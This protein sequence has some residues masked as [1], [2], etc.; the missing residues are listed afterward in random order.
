[1][2]QAQASLTEEHQFFG[3]L[4]CFMESA[5]EDDDSRA[6]QV[7]QQVKKICER[8]RFLRLQDYYRAHPQA[9]TQQLEEVYQS[10]LPGISRGSG[11]SVHQHS[12]A[13]R[14]GLPAMCLTA[15]D[16]NMSKKKKAELAKQQEATI[17]NLLRN[18]NVNP[19]P[20]SS[21]SRSRRGAARP[22][23]T[24]MAAGEIEI[25]GETYTEREFVLAAVELLTCPEINEVKGGHVLCEAHPDCV[26]QYAKPYC[27]YRIVADHVHKTALLHQHQHSPGQEHHHHQR[28]KD[29]LFMLPPLQLPSGIV[30]NDNFAQQVE[31]NKALRRARGGTTTAPQ[32]AG[33]DLRREHVKPF[34]QLETTL[35]LR[36]LAWLVRGGPVLTN[37]MPNHND[38][39][40]FPN[41]AFRIGRDIE[42]SVDLTG[43]N[44]IHKRNP[45]TTSCQLNIQEMLD[46]IENVKQKIQC[47]FLMKK[48]T[49]RHGATSLHVQDLSRAF[50]DTS[51]GQGLHNAR[52]G[53]NAAY[54][55]SSHN[56][57]DD[58]LFASAHHDSSSH[59]ST[60]SRHAAMIDS[61]TNKYCSK[62]ASTS[63]ESLQRVCTKEHSERLRAYKIQM[64]DFA[65]NC[66]SYGP[67]EPLHANSLLHQ[68]ISLDDTNQAQ[69]DASAGLPLGLGMGASKVELV[70]LDLL[71]YTIREHEA[72]NTRVED[73][74]YFLG[75][76]KKGAEV[77]KVDFYVRLRNVM[78]T[79]IDV[80]NFARLVRTKCNIKNDP[81]CDRDPFCSRPLDFSPLFRTI[82][83]P[84]HWIPMGCQYDDNPNYGGGGP[85]GS[86]LTGGNG[87]INPHSHSYNTGIEGGRRSNINF[88]SG[89]AGGAGVPDHPPGGGMG[90]S[91]PNSYNLNSGLQGAGAQQQ[92]QDQQYNMMN[93]R[94]ASNLQQAALVRKQDVLA[95]LWLLVGHGEENENKQH[96]TPEAWKA[97]VAGMTKEEMEKQKPPEMVSVMWS[98]SHGGE[99]TPIHKDWVK[100]TGSPLQTSKSLEFRPGSR[101]CVEIRVARKDLYAGK[102]L[103]HIMQSLHELHVDFGF[104]ERD[105]ISNLPS[106]KAQAA[107]IFS[108]AHA[109]V[110]PFMARLAN[111]EADVARLRR[112]MM[113]ENFDDAEEDQN[114]KNSLL[115]DLDGDG[116]ISDLDALL[117]MVKEESSMLSQRQAEELDEAIE[118]LDTGGEQINPLSRS[119]MAALAAFGDAE[120]DDDIVQEEDD[121]TREHHLRHSL[122]SV[123]SGRR[124]SKEEQKKKRSAIQT[125]R[126]RQKQK[127]V[128]KA[129]PWNWIRDK[130]KTFGI[131]IQNSVNQTM[132]NVWRNLP[133]M[134]RRKLLKWKQEQ[135]GLQTWKMRIAKALYAHS[136]TV[137]K[138]YVT[139]PLVETHK[140]SQTLQDL[141]ELETGR[142]RSAEHME[143]WIERK[144]AQR[145]LGSSSGLGSS[146]GHFIDAGKIKKTIKQRIEDIQNDVPVVI[147]RP[148]KEGEGDGVEE[149][150]SNTP[151]QD[152]G[153][154][155]AVDQQEDSSTSK[156][157]ANKNNSTATPPALIALAPRDLFER[158]LIAQLVEQNR[159]RAREEAVQFEEAIGGRTAKTQSARENAPFDSRTSIEKEH[160]LKE[161]VEQIRTE[162][163]LHQKRYLD[164]PLVNMLIDPQTGA[165]A[166]D[167]KSR[168]NR[169]LDFFNNSPFICYDRSRPLVTPV[170]L[171]KRRRYDERMRMERRQ[172]RVEAVQQMK[173]RSQA[174]KEGTYGKVKS[175]VA[176]TLGYDTTEQDEIRKLAAEEQNIELEAE[177]K[178]QIDKELALE[179]SHGGGSSARGTT[180]PGVHAGTTPSAD[181][182]QPSFFGRWFSG[183]SWFGG[184]GDGETQ[185]S[186]PALGSVA[187]DLVDDWAR[188]KEDLFKDELLVD[189]INSKS[190]LEMTILENT[191]VP[192]EEQPSPGEPLTALDC[193]FAHLLM[194][195]VLEG[196]DPRKL[197]EP[198]YEVPFLSKGI[199]GAINTLLESGSTPS[200]FATS[201]SGGPLGKNAVPEPD[202]VP[203]PPHPLA[204]HLILS[205]PK[206]PSHV[207]TSDGNEILTYIDFRSGDPVAWADPKLMWARGETK[208]R[209]GCVVWI[210]LSKIRRRYKKSGTR[211]KWFKRHSQIGF[212]EHDIVRLIA[213]QGRQMSTFKDA[214]GLTTWSSN[215]GTDRQGDLYAPGRG[216]FGAPPPGGHGTFNNPLYHSEGAGGPYGF[217]PFVPNPAN[218]FAA[219]AE[220][221]QHP[222]DQSYSHA[223]SPSSPAGAARGPGGG[224]GYEDEGAASAYDHSGAASYSD[225]FN[226]NN[227]EA[228][229]RQL[230]HVIAYQALPMY[231]EKLLQKNRYY[232]M[233]RNHEFNENSP[234]FVPQNPSRPSPGE[235][236]WAESMFYEKEREQECRNLVS[237]VEE[238]STEP[239][240]SDGLKHIPEKIVDRVVAE[241]QSR[242]AATSSLRGAKGEGTENSKSGT[243][244]GKSNKETGGT[245][246]QSRSSGTTSKTARTPKKIRRRKLIVPVVKPGTFISDI[247]SLFNPHQSEF[248]NREDELLDM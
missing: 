8:E 14:L 26:R 13:A 185:S 151:G 239:D 74:P 57:H 11:S 30:G 9:T 226:D 143:Q 109:D 187:G 89:A 167:P 191:D 77:E 159:I 214:G 135:F 34:T 87:I 19:H 27:N 246:D 213:V 207:V 225:A 53:P 127:R 58:E 46:Y 158:K 100:G 170:Q 240:T 237:T 248:A 174:F 39:R 37:E 189:L 198:N 22:T 155:H 21:N 131:T 184:G 203:E 117:H 157:Q 78:Q 223:G 24:P 227:G 233:R 119:K 15:T 194:Q 180:A 245:S 104:G 33:F 32:D 152:A 61:E 224:Y 75:V 51:S 162:Q 64:D 123:F 160:D 129:D 91:T 139:V 142:Y 50:S 71:R 220:G 110:D 186:S 72:E 99:L 47:C 231:Q 221:A 116:K 173:E 179:N 234:F 122:R 48:A 35:Y 62:L 4:P 84:E 211:M 148:A 202:H 201:S 216:P 105:E 238:I 247:Q 144:A 69:C 52:T 43:G 41:P 113:A 16:G 166:I 219:A 183:S 235:K 17:A 132:T 244:G 195:Q 153:A 121:E 136:V 95:T 42:M 206:K 92:I 12:T 232:V 161:A 98:S 31:E 81:H 106:K 208:I 229:D 146:P 68:G 171:L 55:S 140:F 230:W 59:R 36:G 54:S 103:N 236:L 133:K 205:I 212:D 102:K 79:W 190:K 94:W 178:A 147:R 124:T 73:D 169:A 197:L 242:A 120:P 215:G 38:Q 7:E 115:E 128:E 49:Q 217:S 96:S 86:S 199:S 111:D 149:S 210:R 114:G 126:K 5:G 141:Q 1:M 192:L 181:E 156:N 101:I 196:K 168:L 177:Q 60:T 150:L 10:L 93:G 80:E 25:N 228:H 134:V 112:L 164:V 56:P 45:I 218:P 108:G 130:V 200:P 125:W 241:A 18:A 29:V 70:V 65:H 188:T 66:I 40:M 209:R 118:D 85:P 6:A 67:L 182:E 193:D 63:R 28:E 243:T 138:F 3:Q 44:S 145:S 88:Y 90:H 83:I 23:P 137:L 165:Q 204:N 176:R 154:D 172:K 107:S 97:Q 2:H 82:N 175:W 76:S 20:K 222:Y 163:D